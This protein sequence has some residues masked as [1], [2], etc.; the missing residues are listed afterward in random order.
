MKAIG[1]CRVIGYALQDAEQDG[2][3]QVF[4]HLD[5]Q[6]PIDRTEEI[7]ALKA[8]NSELDARVAALEQAVQRLSKPPAPATQSKKP[9]RD[10]RR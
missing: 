3:I 8:R 2:T 4:A 6:Q 7:A 1:G 5:E 10:R 9:L